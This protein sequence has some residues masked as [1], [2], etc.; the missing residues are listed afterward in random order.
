MLMKYCTSSTQGIKD[1]KPIGRAQRKGACCLTSAAL[2]RN[3][4]VISSSAHPH[5]ADPRAL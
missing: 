1:Q 4:S 2:A 3:A 5:R